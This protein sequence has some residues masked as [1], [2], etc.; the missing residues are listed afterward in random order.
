MGIPAINGT[1]NT[2]VKKMANGRES[3]K[4]NGNGKRQA[5][6][7]P[8]SEED[9]R[10][11]LVKKKSSKKAEQAGLKDKKKKSSISHEAINPAVSSAQSSP[12]PVK[13][14]KQTEE[15]M[16]RL[17]EESPSKSSTVD[18]GVPSTKEKVSSPTP[19]S[20]VLSKHPPLPTMAEIRAE[21]ATEEVNSPTETAE[22]KRKRLK[23]ERKKERKRL[24]RL[25]KEKSKE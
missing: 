14:K 18:K 11:K 25:E 4:V 16:D 23:R 10:S 13:M 1:A 22:E 20:P 17:V 12:A 21:A 2:D 6:R 8:D 19:T 15:V 24:K 5:E 7:E 9:S 3:G